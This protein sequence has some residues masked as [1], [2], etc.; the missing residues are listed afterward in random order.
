VI[1]FDAASPVE[2]DKPRRLTAEELGYSFTHP[3]PSIGGVATDSDLT[4]LS[5][6]DP[7]LRTARELLRS[8]GGLIFTGPPGTS[9]SYYASRVAVSLAGDVD[10][11]RFVQFHPSYQY[12]DFVTGYVPRKDGSGF[13]LAPKHLI[14]LCDLARDS[15]DVYVLV[16]DE[17]SRGDP[18]RIF[19]EA[20]TY[21][22]R[23]KRGRS[24]QLASGDTVAI[25]PNLV[26]LA[27]MNP[28]D[29]G[30]DEVDAAFERRFAKIL[31]DP[32]ESLLSASLQENNMDD[33]LRERLL[34]FFR[35]VQKRSRRNPAAAVG[36]TYFMQALDE[37][38]LRDVWNHQLK[39]HFERAFR[40]D[41]ETLE[42]IEAAWTLVVSPK[43]KVTSLNG[44]DAYA[45]GKL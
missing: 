16:I 13:D 12:E 25:P 28:L 34:T 20:L 1:D 32:D 29:R 37:D 6:D 43:V 3:S 10:R 21:V 35:D 40:L 30:V 14:Q 17:L 44:S 23:S 2:P 5:P 24:F 33:L 4:P 27:T 19:G 7:V 38:D 11:V 39:F 15:G 42:E 31:M 9:K 8:Y 41:R 45:S 36:H 26:I 22:E 18:G